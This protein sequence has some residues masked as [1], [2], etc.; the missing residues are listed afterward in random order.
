MHA[1]SFLEVLSFIRGV[2]HRSD[3]D[4]LSDDAERLVI[5]AGLTDAVAHLLRLVCKTVLLQS[6]GCDTHQIE[7]V[8][9]LTDQRAIGLWRCLCGLFLGDEAAESVRNIVRK[10]CAAEVS[11]CLEPPHGEL[12]NVEFDVILEWKQ[13]AG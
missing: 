5:V 2:I 12:T 13:E 11:V 3:V 1:H 9:V 4:V 6:A 10:L 8:A 7:D